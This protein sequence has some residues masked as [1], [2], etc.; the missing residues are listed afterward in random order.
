MS[1][2]PEPM[3]IS[4]LL[5]HFISDAARIMGKPV[6]STGRR[7]LAA[8]DY[9]FPDNAGVAGNG[10]RCGCQIFFFKA[11]ERIIQRKDKRRTKGYSFPMQDQPA[12]IFM[13]SHSTDF[14]RSDG[15]MKN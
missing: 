3:M 2:S 15:Q 11:F 5:Q 8:F 6:P 12:Q 10:L 4:V 7:R 14:Q 9:D 13:G 1:L